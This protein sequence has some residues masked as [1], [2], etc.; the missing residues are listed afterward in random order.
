[1]RNGTS[2]S[3]LL[4]PSDPTDATS[5]QVPLSLA[6][7][8]DPASPYFAN[9]DPD[10]G[11]ILNSQFLGMR[12]ASVGTGATGLPI[13]QHQ[14]G[15]VPPTAD[16]IVRRAG[17][18]TTGYAENAWS[19]INR[20]QFTEGRLRGLVLGVSS[21][22]QQK[23]RA[24]RYTDAAA[25][26]V[27]RTFYYPDRVQQNFFGVYSFKGFGKTRMSV[28]L[29]IDNLLDRQKLLALPRGT[30]GVVRYFREQYT[31]RKSS[32]TLNAFF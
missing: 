22:Y 21:I 5:A 9:L 15:F 30:N 17:E 31:P 8:K 32:L 20:Y 28:Q 24:Y 3:P 2:L 19:M 13:T 1:M 6:M 27:R 29:N 11:Q 16:I 12:S 26:N 23:F 10:S 14:L 18:P 7:L 4:V 25:G